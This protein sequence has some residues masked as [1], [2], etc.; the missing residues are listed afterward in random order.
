MELSKSPEF[1]AELESSG[2]QV[3]LE[4]SSAE[5]IQ[6]THFNDNQT[7]VQAAAGRGSY[8]AHRRSPCLLPLRLL[9]RVPGQRAAADVQTV[10]VPGDAR[11]GPPHRSIQAG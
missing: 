1:L 2:A 6:I 4:V 11:P 3:V 9:P 10:G 7:P 8:P 5:N